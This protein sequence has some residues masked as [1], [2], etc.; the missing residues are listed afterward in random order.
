MLRKILDAF[1]W[2]KSGLVTPSPWMR[3]AF[4]MEETHA[5]VDVS[6]EGALAC[7]TVAACVRL[8]SET[9]ASLPL[10]V[11]REDGES[12]RKAPEHALYSLVHDGPNEFQT[13]YTWRVQAMTNTLLHGNAYTAIERDASGRV[14]ALWPL[15]PASVR[16]AAKSDRL[17]YEHWSA[18]GKRMYEHRD[19][20]HFRGPTLDGITGRSIVS[21]A[22]QG[23]GLALAQDQHGATLFRN[24]ARPG[25]VIRVP[26]KLN[27]DARQKM[28]TWLETVSAGL[29]KGKSVVLE[30]GMELSQ[31]GFS[32]EDAQYLQ[33]R[34]FSVQDICRWFRIPPHLVGDPT[35]L[36]YSSSEVEMI[37]FTTHSLRPWLVNFES[38]LNSKLFPR[39]SGFFCEFDAN[40]L[41]RGDQAT[42][43]AAYKTGI[44]AGF[45]QVPDV[46]AWENLPQL[47]ESEAQRH[48]E[49]TAA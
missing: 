16:V 10:H 15:L 38:E 42:R 35:R 32:A 20:I 17:Q 30:A 23:I 26:E 41:A 31:Y 13:S 46:R 40:A 28:Q 14:V 43:Y 1:R 22:R 9:V 36:A 18:S 29:N 21:M 6:A 3:D 2:N 8:L 45:L 27:P 39:R 34:Q 25:A 49:R 19:V 48:A 5:G 37:A 24:Q 44:D 11:F 12:K 7:S 47:S 33:S 4:G